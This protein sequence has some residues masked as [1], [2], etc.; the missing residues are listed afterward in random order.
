LF[1]DE[2]EDEDKQERSQSISCLVQIRHVLCTDARS[3]FNARAT[4]A[5]ARQADRRARVPGNRTQGLDPAR[6]G[7][8]PRPSREL[9]TRGG[10]GFRAGGEGRACDYGGEGADARGD[11][12][13]SHQRCAFPF[14]DLWIWRRSGG[15]A[16]A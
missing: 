16:D 3:S 4:A 1:D 9:T 13:G 11:D 12:Q 14:P 15:G 7:D 5:C 6:R 10:F 2:D 8:V